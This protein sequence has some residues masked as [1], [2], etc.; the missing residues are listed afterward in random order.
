MGAN[1]ELDELYKF[2]KDCSLTITS[3]KPEINVS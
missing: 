1:A 3:S 2:E